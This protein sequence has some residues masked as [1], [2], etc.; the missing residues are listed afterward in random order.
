MSRDR[1]QLVVERHRRRAITLLEP[2]GE[3]HPLSGS[4]QRRVIREREIVGRDGTDGAGLQ[5]V[6]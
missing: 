2:L 5:E 4:V 1:P 3:M 6:G